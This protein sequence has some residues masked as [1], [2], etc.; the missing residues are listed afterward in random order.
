MVTSAKKTDIRE[1]STFSN[2]ISYIRNT[3]ASFSPSVYWFNSLFFTSG[4]GNA[5]ITSPANAI[6][7]DS[8]A[9]TPNPVKKPGPSQMLSEKLTHRLPPLRYDTDELEPVIDGRTLYLHHAV[10]HASYVN[11]LNS[12]LE[13]LPDLHGKTP[14]WLLLNL[15]EVPIRVRSQV[16]DNASAHLNHSL[17]W[18]SMTPNTEV[19]S[20]GNTP[21]GPLAEAINLSFGNFEAFKTKFEETGLK[22][23]SSGWIWLVISNDSSLRLM[24]TTGNINPLS[25]GF[26]PLLAVDVWEH[27]YYLKYQ[28]RID[29]YLRAWWSVANWVEIETRYDQVLRR[30]IN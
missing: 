19:V 10:H 11:Q 29:K 27:A 18:R 14:E 15:D 28:N 12:A 1:L 8:V 6:I 21:T 20:N 23:L 22:L 16:R 5:A 2:L 13:T 7:S 17:M 3:T 26:E 25:N 4:A 9:A 30:N 24:T